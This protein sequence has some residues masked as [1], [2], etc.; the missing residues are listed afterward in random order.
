MKKIKDD[1]IKEIENLN[2]KAIELKAE[3]TVIKWF[4]KKVA[5]KSLIISY[6]FIIK[7]L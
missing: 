2:K 6:Y 1:H 7:R 4:S 5:I 3:I